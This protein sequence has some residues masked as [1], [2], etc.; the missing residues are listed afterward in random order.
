MVVMVTTS[1]ID[2]EIRL[3]LN[4]DKSADLDYA[5]VSDSNLL[6]I[7]RKM[8]LLPWPDIDTNRDGFKLTNYSEGNLVGVKAEKHIQSFEDFSKELESIRSFSKDKLAIAGDI[9]VH[10][11]KTTLF[12][13]KY[14]LD[15]NI[16]LTK[17]RPESY[18]KVPGFDVS[19]AE[20][21]LSQVKLR[22]LL[23]TPYRVESSNADKV[24]ESE[25]TLEWTLRTGVDNKFQAKLVAPGIVNLPNISISLIVLLVC[26]AAMASV[27]RKRRGLDEDFDFDW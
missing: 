15:G 2:G 24:N 22:F 13:R 5:V 14:L 18:F 25:N 12:S 27:A 7:L 19:A 8:N 26:I 1:C 4:D 10:E 20:L 9:H 23:T 16:D 17:V 21:L 11:T 3:K 6:A